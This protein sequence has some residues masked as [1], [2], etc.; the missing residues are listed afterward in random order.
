LKFRKRLKRHLLNL[1]N[2]SAGK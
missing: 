1:L 2:N